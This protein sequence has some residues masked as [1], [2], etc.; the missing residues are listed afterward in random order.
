M[1]TIRLEN[2]HSVRIE[3][4]PFIFLFRGG[5]NIFLHFRARSKLNPFKMWQWWRAPCS[6]FKQSL[7]TEQQQQKSLSTVSPFGLLYFVF[8][9]NVFVV[10]ALA[11]SSPMAMVACVW[12]LRSLRA[13]CCAWIK[14][15]RHTATIG[16]LELARQHAAFFFVLFFFFGAYYTLQY[17]CCTWPCTIR[18]TFSKAISYLSPY[19]SYRQTQFS[20]HF[21]HRLTVCTNEFEWEKCFV[22]VWEAERERESSIVQIQNLSS[23]WSIYVGSEPFL[24]EQQAHLVLVRS[25]SCRHAAFYRCCFF[26][27]FF[28]FCFVCCRLTLTFCH[29]VL[30]Q[31]EKVIDVD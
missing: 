21:Y 30:T 17:C 7:A 22:C 27:F 16:A 19:L 28:L 25:N 9:F 29:F 15:H 1:L 31:N 8:F 10:C 5:S 12:L 26:Y 14:I 24:F 11:L 23:M 4:A 18:Y 20:Y 6:P 13:A 2:N 3:I